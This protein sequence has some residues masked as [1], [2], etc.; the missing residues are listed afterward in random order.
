MISKLRS[1]VIVVFAAGVLSSGGSFARVRSQRFTATA[2]SVKGETA[3]GDATHRRTAAADP[4]VIP[5]GSRIRIRGAGKYSG[6]Y[7]VKDT[8]P[9]VKGRQIDI[10]I[11]SEAAAKRFGKKD[12]TVE[13]LNRVDTKQ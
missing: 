8:G 10:Y 9:K 5:L 13:I 2:Y 3:T 1:R 4:A 7:L 12:V 6:V 11:P